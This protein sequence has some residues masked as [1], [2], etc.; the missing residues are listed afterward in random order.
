MLVDFVVCSCDRHPNLI[1]KQSLFETIIS[2]VPLVHVHVLSTLF[3]PFCFAH[4]GGMAHKTLSPA[5]Q[6]LGFRSRSHTETGI[7]RPTVRMTKK[8]NIQTKR[9]HV[10][11]SLSSSE[12]WFAFKPIDI[13][14][15]RVTEYQTAPGHFLR[16]NVCH[17]HVEWQSVNFPHI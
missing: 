16:V 14:W 2:K 1:D 4:T 17:S 8:I 6:L 12:G 10:P 3:R 7:H 13:H 15:I 5:A 9:V 11:I